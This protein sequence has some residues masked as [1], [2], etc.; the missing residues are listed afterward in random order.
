MKKLILI[1]ILITTVN[2]Y[3]KV[4]VGLGVGSDTEVLIGVED[5]NI[6]VG[7][8][9]DVSLRLDKHF[10]VPDTPHFYWGLGGKVSE[11]DDH[12]AGLR[13]IA[14]LNFF[15]EREVELYAQIVPTLYLIEDTHSD[16]EYSLGIRYWLD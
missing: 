11:D 3:S 6:G 16:I 13:G 7:L 5:L 12:R 9:D 8:G 2:T 14:G 15:P 4:G 10:T 1:F